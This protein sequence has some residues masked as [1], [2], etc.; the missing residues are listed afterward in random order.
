MTSAV[1]RTN[2][3]SCS[4]PPTQNTAPVLQFNCLFTHDLRKKRKCWHDGSLDFHTFN[5]RIMVYDVAR[6]FIGD[7]HWTET[8]ALQDGDEVVLEK[9]GILVQVGDSKGTTETDLTDLRNSRK[10]TTSKHPSLPSIRGSRVP[11]QTP[12]A[13]GSLA[14][15]PLKHR[16]LNAV[17]GAPKGPIGKAAV[18]SKSPFEERQEFQAQ[19]VWQDDRPTKR[20]RL[21]QAPPWA[22]SRNIN[23][24]KPRAPKASPMWARTADGL[25]KRRA[26]VPIEQGQQRLGTKEIIDLC[27]DDDKFLNGF[28]SDAL[29][30]D[31]S[32]QKAVMRTVEATVSSLARSSSPAFQVQEAPA[33][34]RRKRG[35]IATRAHVPRPLTTSPALTKT[36][37]AAPDTAKGVIAETVSEN[38]DRRED[39]DDD[40][41]NTNTTAVGSD[42]AKSTTCKTSHSLRL[43]ACVSRRKG[44]LCQ[45]QLSKPNLPPTSPS[46]RLDERLVRIESK[47]QRSLNNE[48]SHAGQYETP[49]TIVV[50]QAAVAADRTSPRLQTPL[51][52]PE[53][54][55]DGLGRLCVSPRTSPPSALPAVIPPPAAGPR[56]LRRAVSENTSAPA[57][58]PRRLL[59]APTRITP[60]PAKKSAHSIIFH[61]SARSP[62]EPHNQDVTSRPKPKTREP[63]KRA[64]SLNVLPS[65]TSAVLLS[66][67]FQAPKAAGTA[68]PLPVPA[69]EPEP[70]SREAF[71]LFEWRPPAWDEEKWCVKADEESEAV[72]A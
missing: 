31:S 57:E 39:L 28:S 62:S 6:N 64:A 22:V 34:P 26:K 19:H 41:P 11:L 42:S 4:I 46:R 59:G 2:A 17:L 3:P 60:S 5:K 27:E 55:I 20:P 48:R 18:P 35:D 49:A 44:L 43:A 70:W 32:P 1:Y 67:P 23:V 14:A 16:S 54:P 50:G 38:K 21:E 33:D 7:A 10:M 71:D 13:T 40:A 66:R 51:E 8:A 12:R 56:E 47:E 36:S 45:D 30:P 9:G 58:R 25:N 37:E 63:P 52:P 15:A 61:A 69:K 24:V 72:G 29:V 53:A 65:G 68:E